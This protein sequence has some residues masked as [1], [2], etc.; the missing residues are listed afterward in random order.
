MTFWYRWRRE[1]LRPSR[2]RKNRLSTIVKK[3]NT[4]IRTYQY[5]GTRYQTFHLVRAYTY[6]PGQQQLDLLLEY[7]DE[8]ENL[9]GKKKRDN[10][11]IYSYEMS[12]VQNVVRGTHDVRTRL[13]KRCLPEVFTSSSHNRHFYYTLNDTIK[14]TPLRLERGKVTGIFMTMLWATRTIASSA[15]IV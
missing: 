8:L 14:N 5:R 15:T 7:L 11:T 6:T 10:R 9:R 2:E 13:A 4:Y 12:F 3:R 1:N